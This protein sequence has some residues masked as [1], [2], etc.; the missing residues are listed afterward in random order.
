[1]VVSFQDLDKDGLGFIK[2]RD[3]MNAFKFFG[4]AK[5]EKDLMRK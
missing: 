4:Q 3:L 5:S 1:M 2:T